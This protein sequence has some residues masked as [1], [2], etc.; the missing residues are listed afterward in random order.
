MD[1]KNVNGLERML[2]MCCEGNDSELSYCY[3]NEEYGIE[4]CIDE[5]G[6]EIFESYSELF[7]L[8]RNVDYWDYK[9]NNWGNF[10]FE[11]DRRDLMIKVIFGD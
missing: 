3:L 2:G 11:L 10:R 7:M 1:F 9:S 6:S 4:N 5:W 8:L